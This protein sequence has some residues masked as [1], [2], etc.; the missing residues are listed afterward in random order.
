MTI[1]T[2]LCVFVFAHISKALVLT[3]GEGATAPTGSTDSV[4]A[5]PVGVQLTATTRSE[6]SEKAAPV[7]VKVT[8]TGSKD[9][10]KAEDTTG[11]D[12]GIQVTVHVDVKS[13]ALSSA[14]AAPPGPVALARVKRA[15]ARSP[16]AVE[17]YVDK[18]SA[19]TGLTAPP[20]SAARWTAAL[21]AV[22][23]AGESR[24]IFA[25]DIAQVQ[26]T[27]SKELGRDTQAEVQA[28]AFQV[29]DSHFRTG[30][31]SAYNLVSRV[32]G[33]DP[34]Q[35]IVV[36]AHYDSIPRE[37]AAP[38]AEDN[39]SGVATLLTIAE[40]LK[41]MPTTLEFSVE[42]V[43]FSAEEEGLYGSK[44]YVRDLQ[45]KGRA[46]HCR[47][48][49][50]L[51]EVSYTPTPG[52]YKLILETKGDSDPNHRIIDTLVAAGKGATPDVSY[53]V[54]YHGFGSDHMSFLEADIPAVLVIERD[55]MAFAS[56]YG[57]TPL[58]SVDKVDPQFG[59]RVASL[60]AGAVANLAG[61]GSGARST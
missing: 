16:E 19:A 10:G 23:G 20:V 35:F 56:A 34:S 36:G 42:F 29:S 58:D 11:L 50:I 21:S 60:V 28:E 12:K 32:Q 55:N 1:R 26:A 18:G 46:A 5:D 43:L 39:G 44:A 49:V 31:G 37:G 27:L 22:L 3:S 30:S 25:G 24:F 38:G 47:G 52:V 8:T 41:R 4:K 48:A 59:A 51:D 7:H 57:H 14:R 15:V 54:N 61:R 13:P 17:A 53:E 6:D 45:Q 33:T 2:V 9:S 40:D